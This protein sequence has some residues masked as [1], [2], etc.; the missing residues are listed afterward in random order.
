MSNV[1][2]TPKLNTPIIVASHLNFI[3]HNLD[4]HHN[5]LREIPVNKYTFFM[6]LFIYKRNV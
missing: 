3:F 5:L 4:L 2:A 6:L 1:T